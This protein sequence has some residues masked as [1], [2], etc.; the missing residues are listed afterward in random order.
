MHNTKICLEGKNRVQN[1]LSA[2]VRVIRIRFLLSSVVAVSVGLAISWWHVGQIDI[3]Y[4]IMTVCG[5]VALHASVDLLNDYWDFKRGIDTQTQRTKMSGGTGV[6]PE[7]LLQPKQ[8]YRAGLGFLIVGTAIGSYFVIIDGV[9][10][11]ILL[12]FAVVSIYFYSTKIV[13]SGLAEVFVAIKG[14]MIVLGTYYIQ[15]LEIN[16]A[17]ILGGIFV[18]VLSSLVLFITSFPDYDADKAKGR[19]TLVIALGKKDAI[20]VFWI[21]PIVSYSMVISGIVYEI[22]PIS[23]IISLALIPL[24]IKAGHE[25]KQNVNDISGM[26]PAM[27]HTIT[28]SRITGALFIIGFLINY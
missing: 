11:G 3:M 4:S 6:L 19:K 28:F 18:G 20:P 22:F 25:L 23:C 7:G 14:T 27:S 1:M 16:L 15:T 17:I 24:L 13:D 26:I 12:A 9:I 10:I 8:V 5:V 21:F 2:W